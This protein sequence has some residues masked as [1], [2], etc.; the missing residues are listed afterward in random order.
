[1]SVSNGPNLGVMINAVTG[2]SFPTDFRKLLRAI[3]VLLQVSVKSKTLS[4]P[5][6]SPANGDRYIV[7][8]G[9]TGAWSG[10]STH[11][12]VWT[13]DN[14][15][16]PSGVWEFYTPQQ[17]WMVPNLGDSTVYVFLSGAWTALSGGGGGALAALSDVVLSSVANGDVLTYNSGSSKWVNAAP[18]GGG[19]SGNV[20]GDTHPVSPSPFDDEFEGGSLS[21]IWTARNS[22]SLSLL[23]G[24]IVFTQT[25]SGSDAWKLI[26]QSVPS[27]P[28]QVGAKIHTLTDAANYINSAIVL[29]ETSSGKIIEFGMSYN[30]GVWSIVVQRFSNFSTYNSTSFTLAL[31]NLPAQKL[32]SYFAINDDNTNRN[33]QISHDGIAWHT[34]FSEGRTAY[35]T[36][37][38]MGIGLDQSASGVIAQMSCD[39]FRKL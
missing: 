20:N 32:P 17:G 24:S 37:D 19:G 39:W 9:A 35:F 7:A 16:S 21:G 28:Y 5:P 27:A 38:A 2:D 3:D 13:T 23:K 12:A 33:F 22:P 14:P 25:G 11:I 36:P 29:Y 8:S 6:G 31:P 26:T 30:S 18:S 34:V 4:A 1:M 15:A 10:H